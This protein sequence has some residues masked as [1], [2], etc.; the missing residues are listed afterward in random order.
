MLEDEPTRRFRRLLIRHEGLRLKV[1]TDTV[2][3]TTIGCGRN[4]T[5]IGISEME[6]LYLLSND[7]RRVSKQAQD[8]FPWFKS[9]S[10]TRQDVVL[11]MVFNLGLAGFSKFKML[12]Q[13]IA[14]QDY[15]RAA[16]EM[17]AS[18][19]AKQVGNRAKELAT[20]MR[21]GIYMDIGEHQDGKLQL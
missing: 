3:K 1:Y 10:V 5:D 20:M 9:I 15:E 16:K 14:V 12:I 11:S 8:A 21:T 13:A 6:A 19:W 17:L 4:L 7:I 2:G 18:L